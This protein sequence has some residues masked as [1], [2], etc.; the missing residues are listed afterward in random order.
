MR[1]RN[2]LALFLEAGTGK[3][4]TV[5]E[6]VRQYLTE[7][8]IENCLV[9]APSP[10]VRSWE[11]HI[12]KLDRFGYKRYEIDMIRDAVTLISYRRTWTKR[13]NRNRVQLRDV[14]DRPWDMVVIDESHR[15]GS[16]NSCQ[17]QAC[18]Q[19]A[20][21]SKYRY[22]LTGTPDSTKYEKLYGQIMF[23]NPSKWRTHGEFKS[24]VIAKYDFFRNPITYHVDYAEGLKREY[25]TVV[26]L[27]D[28][29]DLPLSTEIDIPLELSARSVYN[30][31]LKGKFEKHGI[32]LM[33]SGTGYQK[34]LQISSGHIKT[35]SDTLDLKTE[36]LSALM[37]IIEGTA[38]KVVIFAR[39]RRSIEQICDLLERSG[40][41]YHRLDGTVDEPVWQ[42][43][44]TD[45]SKAI[46][47]Q[48][49][50]GGV[51]IDLFASNTCVFYEPT[52]SAVDLEQAKARIMRIG[53]EQHCLYY[54]FQASPI[55]GKAWETVRR[56][57]DVS[58]QMLDDWAKE[59][60]VRQGKKA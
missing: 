28:C 22:I 29:V 17:T 52:F 51:G 9:I 26:R 19:I 39:Y 48:Y 56:G 16:H 4:N 41:D 37:E 40:I 32:T 43:F 46:V 60:R 34:L 1:T 3:T 21:M 59:E 23:L 10:L 33:G 8:K 30:D 49:Q 20:R 38:E 42:V 18:L 36:K 31:I 15:L 13:I 2:A 58:S 50:K 47:V 27:R 6:L 5:L 57:V 55:E 45:D 44:Q 14:V 12:E 25:G 11:L 24:K 54:Y 53:Q 35:D 7:G